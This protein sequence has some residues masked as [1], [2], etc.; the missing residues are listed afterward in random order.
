M[1]IL[2]KRVLTLALL[3]HLFLL[4]N[5]FAKQ[6]S[7]EV[8]FSSFEEAAKAAHLT[9]IVES[10]KVG[11]FSSDVSGYVLNYR[12]QADYDED[13][14]ILR[15][16]VLS[17]PISAMNSDSESRDEK[18]HKLCMG[19][20]DFKEIV[21]TIAGPI[22]LK[23]YKRRNYSGIVNIRG[24]NK[25]F[26]ISFKP[27]FEQQHFTLRGESE[28]SLKKMEIPDPSIAVAKLSDEIRLKISLSHTLN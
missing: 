8:N 24:K 1:R 7:R 22:F 10:T 19:A 3:G 16:M 13:N 14:K 4:N 21:V 28:W 26:V 12:Y 2:L 23:D 27:T 17:F 5:S 11:L 15:N 25:D 20:P 18:L 9:W 6:I